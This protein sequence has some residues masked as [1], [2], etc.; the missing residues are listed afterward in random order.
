MKIKNLA[1]VLLSL[2]LTVAPVAPLA[3]LGGCQADN[4]ATAQELKQLEQLDAQEEAAAQKAQTAEAEAA[5]KLKAAG[6]AAA[7]LPGAQTADEVAALQEQIQAN[8]AA[9]SDLK[10]DWDAAV[11]ELEALG[12]QQDELLDSIGERQSAAAE[13]VLGAIDPRLGV[14]AA[15]LGPLVGR[16]AF[17]RSRKRLARGAKHLAKGAVGDFL[18]DL[19]KAY[20]LGHSSYDPSELLAAAEKLARAKGDDD[21]VQKIMVAKESTA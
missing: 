12:E 20:G 6:D 2:L 11:A 5:E 9:F 10:A 4:Y 15:L 14:G 8:M 3:L 16:L 17:A 18:V 21:L 1:A 19:G 7:A 13:T